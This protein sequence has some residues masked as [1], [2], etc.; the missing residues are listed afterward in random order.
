LKRS[1]LEGLTPGLP[2]SEFKKLVK[3]NLIYWGRSRYHT[4]WR[5][6]SIVAS[7]CYL[8]NGQEKLYLCFRRQTSGIPLN[9]E[10]TSYRIFEIGFKSDDDAT[11]GQDGVPQKRLK[12]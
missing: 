2:T 5:L 3:K 8:P 10:F 1:A 4:T 11:S 9:T 6:G 12:T 7:Y